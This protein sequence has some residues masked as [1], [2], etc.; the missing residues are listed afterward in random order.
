MANKRNDDLFDLLRARGL[1]RKVAKPLATLED[2]RQKARAEG[3]KTAKQ[4]MADLAAAVEDIRTR[5][6]GAG[7]KRTATAK[8]APKKRTSTA[9]KTTAKKATTTRKKAPAARKTTTTRKKAPAAKKTT[10]TRKKA[11]AA[12]KTTTTRKKAPA[13]KKTTTTRKKAPAAKKTTTTR[14]KAPAA[15]K[16]T[17]TK[18]TPLA[19][20]EQPAARLQRRDT[21]QS[22]SRRVPTE[23]PVP[24]CRLHLQWRSAGKVR[25][26]RTRSWIRTV[27]RASRDS[28]RTPN[29]TRNTV[30]ARRPLR[31]FSSAAPPWC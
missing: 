29:E 6:L 22:E 7:S 11:P 9:K 28:S 30:C 14:K 8:K 26:W 10:T 31:S 5:V 24:C 1:R 3:E 13:A 4:A 12:K 20:A 18:K 16:T 15:K 27:L 19:H 2:N 23:T 17:K 25:R 21:L